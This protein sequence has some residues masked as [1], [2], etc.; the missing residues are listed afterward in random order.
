MNEKQVFESIKF[1]KLHV[2]AWFRLLTDKEFAYIYN[3]YGPDSWPKELRGALTWI[4][5]NFKEVA[6][7]H[8]VEFFFSQG[9]K[10]GFK[11]TVTHW[12]KN[13]SI[14]LNDRYPLSSPSL[15]VHRS[16]AW[17]KL[18][19]ARRAISGQSAYKFYIEAGKR[20]NAEVEKMQKHCQKRD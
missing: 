11:T 16:I 1:H 7:C 2:C 5:G 18:Y 14:M 10:Q 9:T 20:R 15:W 3:G 12:K 8:D 13:T 19:L 6:G 4:F 17:T